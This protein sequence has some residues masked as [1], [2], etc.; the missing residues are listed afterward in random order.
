MNVL[1]WFAS[2]FYVLKCVIR[3]SAITYCDKFVTKAI[4]MKVC[5]SITYN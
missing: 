1:M 5:P 2:W 4:A 3:L